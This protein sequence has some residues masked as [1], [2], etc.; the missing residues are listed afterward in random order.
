MNFE[1]SDKVKD[2]QARVVA[3]MDEHVY[4]LEHDYDRHVAEAGGWTTPPVIDELKEKAK[5]TGLWNLFMPDERYGAGLTNLEYAPL[6]E[7]M[8]RV[9]W[10]SEVFN[11][12]APDTGN[13]ETL[14]RY[15]DEDQKKRWLEPLLTGEIRSCFSMTEPAVASSDATNIECRITRDGDDYVINGR[16][17]FSSGFANERCRLVIVMGK[18]APDDPD[19]Y[20][21]QSMI[22]V[23]K[24]A[25][26]LRLER[27]PTTF[28]YTGAPGGHPEIVFENVRVPASSILLGE[29]R[30]FEIAQGRLGPGRIHHC[31]RFIGS[32][33]RALELMCQRAESRSAFGRKL[34]EHGS[35]R[36]DIAKSFCDIEQARLLTL[37]AADKM[38]REGSKAA[39]DLIAAAKIVVPKMATEV[40]DRAMQVHGAKG[41][42]EDTFLP[43]AWTW[44]RYIRVGDGPDQVH[45]SSLARQLLKRHA[46]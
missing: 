40:I 28:G 29:G 4:P 15:A 35:L 12:S 14:A 26:G 5:A 11:C 17:W 2:L 18:T 38:D 44:A 23:P 22:L 43:K 45:M 6:A 39:R 7:I 36:E 46:G 27:N 20:R 32:A 13:M 25:P 33:Q 30:G 9:E 10:A 41:F 1:T 21:Q 3:F 34:S 16:K 19:R 8:G 37:M 42:T 31:M 24:D